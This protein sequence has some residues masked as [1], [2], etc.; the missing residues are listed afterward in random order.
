MPEPILTPQEQLT[1]YALNELDTTERAHVEA[2]LKNDANAQAFVNDVRATAAQL[3][4]ELKKERLDDLARA[5]G[6]TGA[7]QPAPAKIVPLAPPSKWKRFAIYGTAAAA[8]VVFGVLIWNGQSYRTKNAPQ[9]SKNA[10]EPLVIDSR[11]VY[12]SATNNED[13]KKADAATAGSLNETA[14]GPDGLKKLEHSSR[15]TADSKTVPAKTP[16]N[17]VASN[18]TKSA[19]KA[20]DASRDGV[21]L[22]GGSKKSN[23]DNGDVVTVPPNDLVPQGA[24][25]FEYDADNSS[26]V[27]NGGGLVQRDKDPLIGESVGVPRVTKVIP[28][29]DT[30]QA[31]HKNV[32]PPVL[33]DDAPA[34]KEL[35]EK[36]NNLETPMP[37]MSDADHVSGL[38]PNNKDAE[39]TVI[40]HGADVTAGVKKSIF[41]KKPDPNTAAYNVDI[42]AIKPLDTN[43]PPLKAPPPTVSVPKTIEPDK[44]NN[45]EGQGGY[46]AVEPGRFHNVAP[47]PFKDIFENS[48]GEPNIP[49]D[50]GLTKKK[51]IGG[52]GNLGNSPAP[53]V[54]KAESTKPQRV[55]ENDPT[56][57]PPRKKVDP[58]EEVAAAT[59][60]PPLK[61]N[62]SLPNNPLDHGARDKKLNPNYP[63]SVTI[64][65]DQTYSPYTPPTTGEA[66]NLYPENRFESVRNAP[67][68]TFSADVDT[69]SF[70]NVRRFLT[71][72]HLP[73]PEAVR[74]E[75]LIN[76]F[77][78]NYDV[79]KSEDPFGVNVEAAACPWNSAH[80]LVRVAIK[81]SG[82]AA[83]QRP[84]SNLVF[85]ID[86]SGSM[87]DP[88]RLPLV[89]EGMKALV[90][91]L[92]END[93]VA[94]VTYAGQSGIALQS[95]NCAEKDRIIGVIDAL[96]AEGETNGGAGI[97][98]AYATAKANFIK[99][100]VNRVILA[101]D[102]DFNVGVTDPNELV[103]MIERETPSGVFLTALGYG[104]G[105]LKD[106]MLQRLANK[107]NGHYAYIDNADESRKVLIE[108]MNA[109]LVAV[110][111]DVKFQVEFNPAQAEWYRLIGYEKRA[112]AAQDFN[113]DAKGAGEI[114]AGH[115]VTAFYEVVPTQ[116]APVPG[117]DPLKYQDQPKRVEAPAT[118]PETA[119]SE[120]L[121]LKIRYK[122]PEGDTSKRLEFAF[123]DRGATLEQATSD[124]K[125]GA[126]VALF[127]QILRHSRYVQSATMRQAV[128]LA[129]DNRGVEEGGY[130]REFIQL[131]G[132][133]GELRGER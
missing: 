131:A 23:G 108:Q 24:G 49:A 6:A 16:N 53:E 69:A 41:D 26:K 31:P 48:R 101:T 113:N 93:H 66:Y 95:T 77:K 70:S 8:L 121:T 128:E 85:L 21:P 33:A 34:M 57:L 37:I 122:H 27:K 44:A 104:M 111:K 62:A 3:E 46:A 115:T 118:K 65:P 19:E 94:I 68:S 91:R 133:A 64:T 87:D 47:T 73:P 112:L 17:D 28:P 52:R 109:T 5:F 71:G 129:D 86:V 22:N 32:S 119:S 80:R 55:D 97:Q 105:N 96:H 106:A 12:S 14:R 76:Y 50:P 90:R 10:D 83:N 117:V 88:K 61:W 58:N 98:T 132:K 120:L 107:G 20:N 45:T 30:A 79:L 29:A 18:D 78:Y 130:R 15:S 116:G 99:G 89:K 4:T 63:E 43:L 114:G 123:T 110:A 36:M 72:N 39:V 11:S 82:L 51:P 100:G 60:K 125:F 126:S 25:V 56:T 103:K 1:A 54:V 102:G 59:V 75:E 84:A 2:Q 127:G 35:R 74:V 7:A 40:N 9:A 124:F 81:A 42:P 67:L 38:K 92:N 13:E